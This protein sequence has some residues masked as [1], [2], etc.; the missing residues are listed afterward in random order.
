MSARTVLN[1]MMWLAVMVYLCHIALGLMELQSMEIVS[2]ANKNI[3]HDGK[4]LR[5]V[6][7]ASTIETTPGAGSMSG[8]VTGGQNWND[9]FGNWELLESLNIDINYHDAV[10]EYQLDDGGT[11]WTKAEDLCG[12]FLTPCSSYDNAVSCPDRSDWGLVLID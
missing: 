1:M 9:S 3:C 5:I 6:L 12:P 7:K 4:N 2:C 10:W 11:F 8:I